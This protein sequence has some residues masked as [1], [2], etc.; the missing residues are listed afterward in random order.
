PDRRTRFS[1]LIRYPSGDRGILRAPPSPGGRSLPMIEA[2]QG[3]TIDVLHL[4][5][6]A[7]LAH[8][9]TAMFSAHPEAVRL[10]PATCRSP[11]P[12]RPRRS[13]HT[14]APQR[15]T[16]A[17]PAGGAPVRQLPARARVRAYGEDTTPTQ[18][19]STPRPLATRDSPCARRRRS[20]VARPRPATTAPWASRPLPV[21][22]QRAALRARSP[23]ELASS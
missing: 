16:T 17:P 11:G 23:R 6:G 22:S 21:T 14:T 1:D 18:P 7:A 19:P 20:P 8:R 9:L 13:Q 3:R 12:S 15:V 2:R 10:F 5:S 4:P